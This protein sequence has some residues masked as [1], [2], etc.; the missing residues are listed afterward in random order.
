MDSR[1]ELVL[2][3]LL[4][5]LLTATIIMPVEEQHA[6]HSWSP[7]LLA[8]VQKPP[9]GFTIVS[10]DEDELVVAVQGPFDSVGPYGADFEVEVVMPVCYLAK[11]DADQ[12]RGT[13]TAKHYSTLQSVYLCRGDPP[14][15]RNS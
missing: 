3:Q 9:P 15:G 5:Q 1:F 14:W 6:F 12:R 10:A 4:L 8:M 2:L 7:E 13:S 11:V